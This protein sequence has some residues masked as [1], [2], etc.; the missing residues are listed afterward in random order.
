MAALLV[1]STLLL[2]AAAGPVDKPWAVFTADEVRQCGRIRTPEITVTPS[3]LLL[4]AQCR[5]ANASTLGSAADASLGSAVDAS[6]ALD[7]MLHAKVVSKSST[8]SGRTWANFTVHTP[9]AHSHGAAI[10]DRVAKQVVS[11][12]PFCH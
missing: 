4:F 8:S 12:G 5:S 7:N 11:H 10:Y 6:R 9:A 3:R 1:A 2:A